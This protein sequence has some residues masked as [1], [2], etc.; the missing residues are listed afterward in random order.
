[1]M[2][3]LARGLIVS[4]Q[5]EE[6]DPF[7]APEYVSLFARAAEMGGAVGIRAR[8]AE[9]VRA[10]RAA[11]KLPLIGLTKSN[12]ADGRVLITPGLED[13]A[14]LL[15]AGADIVAV[16]ATSRR[17]PQGGTGAQFVAAALTAFPQCVILADVA[18]AAEGAAAEE[19]GAAA[20][21]TTLSGYTPDTEGRGGNGPDW[22]LLA[23]LVRVVRIPVILEGR[24]GSPQEAR[25]A[26]DIGAHAVVAG[27]AIT[28]PRLIVAS[29]VS[30][31]A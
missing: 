28:R 1:M 24:V 30:A 29:Y 14:A 23:E 19:A 16:D 8:E 15:A 7:Y 6:G 31:L 20:V 10:I 9:N 4:C 27:T 18:T 5:A 12:Y 22:E 26:L 21:A 25:R 2:D 11:V 17:R 13:V 3:A